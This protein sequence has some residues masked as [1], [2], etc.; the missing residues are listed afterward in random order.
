V[1]R[2]LAAIDVGSNTVHLLVAEPDGSG[3]LREL[4]HEVT[5][6]RLGKAVQ[7]TGSVGAEKLAQLVADVGGMADR[8]RGMDAAIL[9]LGAT[10]AMRRAADREAALAALSEAAG[11]MCRLIT[12]DAEARLSFRGVIGASAGV[13]SILVA[14]IGGG[15]TEC[16]LGEDG[17][18]VALGSVPAGSGAVTESWLQSDPPTAEQLRAAAGAVRRLMA[19]APDGTPETGRVTGGTANTL[20]LL[21]GRGE[22]TGELDR[23]DLRRCRE[24]LASMPSAEVATVYRIEPSRARVLAGGVEIVEAVLDRYALDRLGVSHQGLRDGMILAYLEVGDDW[25]EG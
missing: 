3:G 20:P 12:P 9:L 22:G 2:R 8:A 23:A 4:R 11:T 19:Q 5:M 1:T 21:L 14:D 17:R 25:V 6:P 10:E 13:R 15:S 16:V 18:I 7:A 24:L